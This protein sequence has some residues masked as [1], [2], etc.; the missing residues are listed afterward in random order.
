MTEIGVACV[1]TFVCPIN[2]SISYQKKK[3]KKTFVCPS[4]DMVPSFPQ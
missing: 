3:K 1:L 4:S 2:F